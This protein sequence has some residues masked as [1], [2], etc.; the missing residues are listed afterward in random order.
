MNT[1]QSESVSAAV[2]R[3]IDNDLQETLQLLALLQQEQHAM[4]QR[5]RHGLTSIVKSKT[6]CM[7]RIEHNAN[8]RYQLLSAHQRPANE[9]GWRQW[10]EEHTQ[11]NI[12]DDW[13]KLLETLEQC[14]HLNEV[15][16]RLINRGQQTLH[17]LLTV[18][19]GQLEA[20]ELYTQRGV[21]ENCGNSHSVTKA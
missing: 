10:V 7:D 3:A 6:I 18:I 13:Q 21:T 16:G 17:H 14:R 11:P 12:R 1:S 19:R 8:I 9:S 15:N 5:D 4:E 20:P 2:H